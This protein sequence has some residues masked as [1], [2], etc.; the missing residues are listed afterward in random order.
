MINIGSVENVDTGYLVFIFFGAWLLASLV[1]LSVW[2]FLAWF[3]R[4]K[5]QR[6]QKRR[7]KKALRR[8]VRAYMRSE[9]VNDRARW[10]TGK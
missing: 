4:G 1:G 9:A 3:Y 2:V 6:R 5:E 10:K 8:Q 7:H